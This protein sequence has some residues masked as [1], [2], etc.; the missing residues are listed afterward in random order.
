MKRL[1]LIGFASFG[2]CAMPTAFADQNA[3]ANI[4]ESALSK[5]VKHL[6]AR[7]ETADLTWHIRDPSI[8]ITTNGIRLS[9]T[10]SYQFKQKLIK[11]QND[12]VRQSKLLRLDNRLSFP[13]RNNEQSFSL[14]MTLQIPG[15]E[16]L[17][18][19]KRN[20]IFKG[21]RS[22]PLG[23]SLDLSPFYTVKSSLY[24]PNY[25]VGNQTHTSQVDQLQIQHFDSYTKISARVW[26]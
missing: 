1:I 24:F 23:L 15:Q 12:L 16:L 7:G 22:Q 11:Q 5:L 14:E 8:D 2:F 9:G 25:K 6:G 18:K 4:Y 3:S 21:T 20:L 17:L 19:P 10:F 13:K 26:P